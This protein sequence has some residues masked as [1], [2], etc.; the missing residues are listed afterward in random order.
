MTTFALMKCTETF[1]A[2]HIAPQKT[3]AM[4]A[5]NCTLTFKAR[6]TQLLSIH[7]LT[8]RAEQLHTVFQT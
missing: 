4:T 3:V 8:H 5:L 6:H 2:S 7:A 1:C